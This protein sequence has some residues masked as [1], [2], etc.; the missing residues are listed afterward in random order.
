MGA[1][2]VV[3]VDR[4]MEQC[5]YRRKQGDSVRVQYSYSA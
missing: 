2:I 3:C 4:N 5:P 1:Y